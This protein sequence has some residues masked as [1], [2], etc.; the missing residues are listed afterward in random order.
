[1]SYPAKFGQACWTLSQVSKVIPA[2][3]TAQTSEASIPYFLAAH[4]PFSRI[5]DLKATGHTLTEEE[6]FQ[7]IFSPAREQV[8]A[9]VT[10]EPGTGK[11]HLIRWLRLRAGYAAH[12]REAGLEKFKLV[13]VSRGTG[14]LKDAL[15]QIVSQLGS[16]FRQHVSRVQSAIERISDS[17][18]R[19]TLLAELALEVGPR[20]SNERRRKSLPRELRH[21]SQALRAEGFGAWF[22]RDGGV[23]H[24]VIQRLTEPTSVEDRETFPS[25]QPADFLVPERHLDLHHNSQDVYDFADDLK[26]EQETREQAAEAMN[27]ALRDA[28]RGLTGLKG[29]DLLDVF[30]EIRREIGPKKSLAVFIED[31]SA[32]SGGLDLDVINALEPRA[33]GDLCRMVAVLGI[34]DSGWKQLQKN[35]KDRGSHIYEVGGLTASSWADDPKEV[36]QFTARYLNA[37]RSTDDDVRNIS[38]SFFS[39]SGWQSK[40]DDCPHK[41]PCHDTFGKVVL[42]GGT[43]VGTF[44]YTPY[45]PQSILARLAEARYRSQRGLL[46]RVLL[47]V[48]D[49]SFKSFASKEFPRPAL[50]GVQPP[51]FPVWAGFTNTYCS[52][53]GWDDDK[54]ARLR[55]LAQFWVAPGSA[56]LLAAQLQPLLEPLGLPKFS[57]AAG[58][59]P[60][61]PGGPTPP[62]PHPP[63]AENPALNHLLRLLDAWNAGQPLKEDNKFR[64]P[65]SKFLARSIVW[66]DHRGTPIAE[67]K[68][69]INLNGSKFPR[70]HDQVMRPGGTY[71]YDFPRNPATFN[72]LQSLII[73]DNA[74]GSSWAFPH[75]ELHKR[76]ISRWLRK[77][78]ARVVASIQPDPPTVVKDVLRPAVE[79]LALTAAIRDRRKLPEDR[80]ERLQAL[81]AAVWEPSA[82]PVVLS[83]EL[84]AITDDLE[85]KHAA[86]RDLLVQELGSGQGDALPKDFLDPVPLL[87]LLDQFEQD[88]EFH[89]PPPEPERSCYWGPRFDA[90]FPLAKGAFATVPKRIDKEREAIAKASQFAA[91]FVKKAGIDEFNLPAGLETC[92]S[93]LIE[94]ITLQ[95]GAQHKRAILPLPNDAFEQLWQRKLVQ[96]AEARASWS[97]ALVKAGEFAK[98]QDRAALLAFDPARLKE[99]FEALKVIEAHLNLID[100]HLKDEEDQ[101]SASGD[102]RPKLLSAS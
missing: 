47:P 49:Q 50:F 99:L 39:T 46:T 71:F 6:V 33:G 101:G 27:T 23:I 56:E 12:N 55:F 45:A 88:T 22:K 53:A 84:Q 66:E 89:P 58:P 94:A 86:L 40:C 21:L 93:Q 14:S 38:D 54:R 36:A 81:F 74:P 3:A 73:F 95:R 28:I 2:A 44:P 30:M 65:L 31:V 102:S 69:L 20:W 10:G 52:G 76:E 80:S 59:P 92:L 17:T 5:T 18:A 43:E 61:K 63:Q 70:I 100:E 9:F 90:A 1:M 4:S 8:E 51:A 82:K 60:K 24:Q 19:A 37:V 13:L 26:E 29:S 32:T 97:V 68:R 91:S 16:D 79:A 64:D 42:P 67:K 98:Q 78:T 15:T 35:Q 11:S 72:L 34:V 75:G 7:E 62:T 25:F 41:R 83:P 87:Q 85:Q 77:N 48:L 96:T 57:R